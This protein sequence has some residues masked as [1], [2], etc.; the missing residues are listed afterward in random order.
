MRIAVQKG[1]GLEEFY[2]ERKNWFLHEDALHSRLGVSL[3][4]GLK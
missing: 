2:F 1:V 4:I 3:E